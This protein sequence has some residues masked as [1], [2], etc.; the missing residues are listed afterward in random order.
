MTYY[1]S[2]KMRGVKDFNFPAFDETAKRLRAYGYQ[3]VSPAEHDRA[4]GFDETKNSLDGFD[5]E[6]ALHWD[7]GQIIKCDGIIILPD[8][9]NSSGV[10]VERAV[11]EMFG[12]E[13]LEYSEMGNEFRLIDLKA[14]ERRYPNSFQTYSGEGVFPS[15]W[16]IERNIL[17]EALQTVK[18]RQSSYGA[19]HENMSNIAEFWTAYLGVPITAEQVA[20]CN[21]LQKV[22]RSKNQY[23]RDNF[24]DVAGYAEVANECN[25]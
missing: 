23:M 21:I 22:A 16:A 8:S 7:I 20:V 24:V 14:T 18:A 4:M 9:E 3:I 25:K 2:A 6:R 13:V 5:L 1:L 10:K 15:Q 11:A 12:K 17:E 19:P